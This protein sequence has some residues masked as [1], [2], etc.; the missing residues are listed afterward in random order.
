MTGVGVALALVAAVAD[1]CAVVLTAS[2]DRRTLDRDAM[3]VSLLRQLMRRRR[4]LAGTGLMVLV[5][6]A[7]IV[8]LAFA[9]IAVVQPLLA[10]SQLVLLAIARFKLREQVGPAEALAAV[11]IVVGL[12]G[13]VYAAPSQSSLAVGAARLAPPLAVVGGLAAAA[14]VV[15]RA[16]PAMRLLLV[17]GAGLAYA[18]TDFIAKLLSDAGASGAWGL[19]AVWLVA[20]LTVGGAAFLEETTALQVRPAVTV[21]PVITAVKVPLPVLM[22]LW[23]GIEPL[24]GGTASAVVLLA[25]LALSAAGAAALG[26]SEVVARLSEPVGSGG[27]GGQQP[28]SAPAAGGR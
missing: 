15:G 1:A 12:G 13:V 25:G 10:T 2:E 17:V 20:L 23:A 9:P 16:R 19:A 14:Y 27:A 28:A 11:A 22:A 4:W 6:V 3:R 21:A 8:A 5:G 18:C 24:R 7:Q 26:R